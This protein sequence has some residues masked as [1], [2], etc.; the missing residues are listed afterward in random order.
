MSRSCQDR[1]GHA[2]PSIWAKY[3]TASTSIKIRR[4]KVPVRLHRHLNDTIYYERMAPNV[5]RFFDSSKKRIGRYALGN[6]LKEIFDVINDPISLHESNCFI[7]LLLNKSFFK[8]DDLP[9]IIPIGR[10]FNGP[11]PF[12]I[13]QDSL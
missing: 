10:C 12:H 5:I 2:R 8:T 3:A 13:E 7:R 11:G 9:P 1:L 6:R 4:D